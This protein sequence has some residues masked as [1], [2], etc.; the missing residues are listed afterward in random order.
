VIR[1]LDESL[2]IRWN[3]KTDRVKVST[4]TDPLNPDSAE[5]VAMTT[6][7]SKTVLFH[8]DPSVRFYFHLSFDGGSGTGENYFVAERFLPLESVN[9]FRDIGGYE[10]EDGHTVHW[11]KVFRSG[12]LCRLNPRDMDYLENLGIKQVFDLRT[13]ETMEKH[14]NRLPPSASL[15]H[16]AVYEQEFNQEVFPALLFRRHKLGEILGSGYIKWLDSGASA[17]GQLFDQIANPDNLP[18]VFHCTAGKDRTGIAAALLYALL[19][20]PNETIIADYTLTNQVFKK[21]YQEFIESERGRRLGIPPSDIKIMLA[22]NPNWIDTT[23]NTVRSK[24]GSA[25]GYLREA[26]GISQG[27]IDAIRTSLLSE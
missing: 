21:L 7:Q 23:L 26:A 24:Y 15:H 27:T 12:N 6:N 3:R 22:A 11:G 18:L 2:E 17:F 20:V 1:H 10:T 13:T 16:S 8:L 14:P 4:H 19:G 9:N 5:I 25:S